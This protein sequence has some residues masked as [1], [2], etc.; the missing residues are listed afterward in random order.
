MSSQST[1]SSDERRRPGQPSLSRAWWLPALVLVA[2]V[3]VALGDCVFYLATRHS[4][5]PLG[6]S[7]QNYIDDSGRDHPYVLFVPY[8]QREPTQKRPVIVFLNGLGENGDDGFRQLSN[9]F[10]LPVW[11]SR[12]RFPFVCI[13]TQMDVGGSW[14]DK[15][16]P[17]VIAT[18]EILKQVIDELNCDPDRVYLTGPSSGGEGV[19]ALASQF[20]DTFAAIAPLATGAP[21]ST[22][23]R[24]AME[25]HP[26]WGFYNRGDRADLVWSAQD[27]RRQCL[28]KGLS[29]LFTEYA[30]TGH[31]CWNAAY[32]SPQLYD[33]FLRQSRQQPVE[34]GVYEI[35]Q[36][37]DLDVSRLAEMQMTDSRKVKAGAAT[38]ASQELLLESPE[39]HFDYR[40]LKTL[41]CEVLVDVNNR[42]Y[43]IIIPA[44]SQG[45]PYILDRVAD[46]IVG[47][48][49][50]LAQRALR[51]DDW[52]DI[53]IRIASGTCL[54]TLNGCRLLTGQLRT[55]IP[56]SMDRV[57][58]GLVL[59]TVPGEQDFRF[60][61]FRRPVVP[62]NP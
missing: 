36:P 41:P 52:N 23:N 24:D 50:P 21:P 62:E 51:Q 55:D 19:Y 7:C 30:G 54:V 42:T 48:G 34:Q 11:E 35:L 33:W 13:A 26:V 59:S 53:R 8:A 2:L 38:G 58:I 56:A 47:T 29:P 16:S 49:N 40:S 10:G 44:A 5:P 31:D 27:Y 32:R 12:L 45:A 15:S 46:E 1:N 14:T 6:F 43:Q 37:D 39:V 20:P 22:C 9:N 4:T 25:K 61:R 18:V 3:V 60:V 17:I 28:H 57:T